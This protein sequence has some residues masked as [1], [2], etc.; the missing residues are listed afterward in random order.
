MCYAAGVLMKEYNYALPSLSA[1]MM[2][3]ESLIDI[4]NDSFYEKVRF[5]EVKEGK[6]YQLVYQLERVYESTDILES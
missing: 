1:A 4:E 5:Y 6:N 3:A 2:V